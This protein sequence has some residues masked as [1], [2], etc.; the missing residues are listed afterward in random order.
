[1]TPPDPA[2]TMTNSPD[3]P[4]RRGGRAMQQR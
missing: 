2:E 1:M 3:Q 4:S